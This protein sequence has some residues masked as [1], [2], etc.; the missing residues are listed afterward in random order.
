[1]LQAV[2]RRR[3]A[4]S[5]VAGLGFGLLPQGELALGLMVGIVSFFE[6]SNGLL[7]AVVAAIVVNNLAGGWW[8]RSSL[9]VPSRENTP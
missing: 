4:V 6:T 2:A 3:H 5:P 9:V 7:E 8:M 1:M